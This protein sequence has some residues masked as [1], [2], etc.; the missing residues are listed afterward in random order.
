MLRLELA[1][2][3]ATLQNFN[4]RVE[5]KGTDKV[6]ATDLKISTAQ[7]PDV[8]AFFAPALKAHLFNESGPRDLADGLPLR[9][10]HM[11]YPLKRDEEML[12]AKVSIEYGVN[13]PLVF[14]DAKLKDFQLTPLQGGTVIVTF[15]V[16]CHPDAETQV[17]KLYV[18]QEQGITLSVEPAELPT[19]QEAAA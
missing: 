16:Q 4:P 5:K 18:L 13:K 2:V 12:N 9:D 8:L 14:D 3:T 17:P 10:P 7:S 15:T 19:M 11:V 6:P 1:G